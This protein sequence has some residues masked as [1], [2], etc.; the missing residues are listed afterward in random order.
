MAHVSRECV[1]VE[2]AGEPEPVCLHFDDA[3]A[4]NDF[5]AFMRVGGAANLS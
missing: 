5:Y 1:G 4:R 2:L 3:S